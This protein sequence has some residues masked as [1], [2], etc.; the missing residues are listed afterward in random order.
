MSQAGRIVALA[1]AA[2]GALVLLLWLLVQHAGGQQQ[3]QLSAQREAYLLRHLRT[4]AE[5][6]L[7]TGLQLE[8]MPALQDMLEREQTAFAGIVAIDVFSPA[9]TVLY[10]TDPGSRGTA[11]PAQ[12]RELLAREQ[13]WQ[14]TAPGQRQVGQR[15]DNDLAQA[16]GGIVITVSTAAAPATLAQWY[17]RSR[18]L[19]RW[20]AAGLLAALTAGLVLHIGLR[21]LGQPYGAAA[22]ILR[23]EPAG[24][25]QDGLQQAAVRQQQGW[26]REREQCRRALAQLEALDHEA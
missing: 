23:G 8:Q 13:P 6:Y 5:S 26:Q 15:F 3:Q 16:A 17:A 25:P 24:A 18:Q 19:L 2:I 22:A 21:R 4:S 11:V 9:G 14:G 10:S 20:L 12:W 1:L 7:A